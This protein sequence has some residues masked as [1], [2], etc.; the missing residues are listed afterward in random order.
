MIG[1][2]Y[3]TTNLLNNKIYIGQ[4]KSEKFDINYYGSGKIIRLAINKNGIKC[5]KC[6]LIEE[7][8][9]IKELNE[10]EK[11]WIAYYR[12][13]DIEMYNIV[14]GGQNPVYFGENHP[15]Y[16]KHH[17]EE[18][19]EKNRLKHLGKHLS[20]E[21]KRKIGEG[22]KGKIIS[23]WQKQKISEANKGRKRKPITEETRKKLKQSKK[24]IKFS[25]EHLQKIRKVAENRKGKKLT[26]EHIQHLRESHLG[27]Q[28][29]WNGKHRSDDTKN[30]LKQ[31]IL[32]RVWITKDNI[33]KLILPEELEDYLLQGFHKGRK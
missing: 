16:G 2:I 30:K 24:G 4:H 28:G 22:N 6:E 31:A 10:K 20:E 19:K 13:Q 18:A 7:C 33:H 26:Q 32:G 3:K 17:T 1:Y 14:E 21:T 27:Q 15:M 23:D 11:Y 25:E 8:N 29:Y 9:T 5:F 12:N